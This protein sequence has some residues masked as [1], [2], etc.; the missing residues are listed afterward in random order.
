[1]A[2]TPGIAGPTA[3]AVTVKI[4]A[5]VDAG[6]DVEIQ[7]TVDA[8]IDGRPE[9]VRILNSSL[10]V[11]ALCEVLLVEKSGCVDLRIEV[12]LVEQHDIRADALQDFSH[13]MQP[14]VVPAA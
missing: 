13:L 10:P 14:I 11:K 1:M 4:Q 12:E 5:T 7:A 6:I 2:K 9:M 8:G 3:A